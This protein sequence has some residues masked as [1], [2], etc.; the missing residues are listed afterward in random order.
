MKKNLFAFLAGAIFSVGL[1]LGGMTRPS[2]VLGFLDVA[3]SWDPSLAFVMMGAVGINVIA[4]RFILR[5]RGP[6]LGGEFVLPQRTAIDRRL[7][8]GAAIFGIGWGLAG[9]CPGPGLVSMASGNAAP[10]LFVAAM[11]V[12]AL[13]Q[14]AYRRIADSAE[15][16]PESRAA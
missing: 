1:V 6:V 11:I 3:G 13:G 8:A 16:A 10:L 14:H 5:R 7:L 2:K 12:G 15:R 9:Y 4:F